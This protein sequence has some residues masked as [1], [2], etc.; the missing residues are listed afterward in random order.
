MGQ[1]IA[2][3]AAAGIAIWLSAAGLAPLAAQPSASDSARSSSVD[4]RR[5]DSGTLRRI[6]SEMAR[7]GPVGDRK[8]RINYA[9][10]HPGVQLSPALRVQYPDTITIVLQHQFARLAVTRSAFSVDLW[11]KGRRERVTVPF[12]AVRVIQ[13]TR[14]DI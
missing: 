2:R 13:D 14:A 5:V 12:A 10:T 6:L 3:A 7:R 4:W 1:G 9:V 11:I 8:V